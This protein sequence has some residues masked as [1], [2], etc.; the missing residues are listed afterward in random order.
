MFSFLPRRGLSPSRPV[1]NSSRPEHDTAALDSQPTGMP[2]GPSAEVTPSL[3]CPPQ[4]SRPRS[5]QTDMA[6]GVCGRVQNSV[7]MRPA[8]TLP[9]LPRDDRA[10]SLQVFATGVPPNSRVGRGPG[11][12]LF[13]V[14][15]PA[16]VSSGQSQ[17]FPSA[18]QFAQPAG[19]MP[20]AG[21]SRRPGC[22]PP[23]PD[24]FFP[25][26]PRP[27]VSPLVP[28]CGCVYSGRN[29]GTVTTLGMESHHVSGGFHS[30]S[31][32]QSRGFSYLPFTASA[33]PE[34]HSQRFLVADQNLHSRLPN[35][36]VSSYTRDNAQLPQVLLPVAADQRRPSRPVQP[37]L[38]GGHCAPPSS[39]VPP[40]QYP[41][42]SPESQ[43]VFRN[44]AR[45]ILVDVG[46]GT[47]PD[48]AA[49]HLQHHRQPQQSS[50]Q[51]CLVPRGE[52]AVA[53]DDKQ[54][55]SAPHGV[56]R[57]ETSISDDVTRIISRE[58]VRKSI[59]PSS[60]CTRIVS[61]TSQVTSYVEDN[62]AKGVAQSSNQQISAIAGDDSPHP[63]SES[64]GVL[65]SL[66]SQQYRMHVAGAAPS[67][68]THEISVLSQTAGTATPGRSHMRR[69]PTDVSQRGTEAAPLQELP[70]M[71]C[72]PAGSGSD[73][74]GGAIGEAVQESSGCFD[75]WQDEHS[76]E[77]IGEHRS[78]Y[79]VGEPDTP[80]AFPPRYDSTE[81]EEMNGEEGWDPAEGSGQDICASLGHRDSVLSE[82]YEAESGT[83]EVDAGGEEEEGTW[84]GSSNLEE[85]GAAN[86]VP[87]LLYYEKHQNPACLQQKRETHHAGAAGAYETNLQYLESEA[88]MTSE[89]LPD[90]LDSRGRDGNDGNGAGSDPTPSEVIGM[91]WAEDPCVDVQL[92]TPTY[93]RIRRDSGTNGHLTSDAK[94]L[95]S[96]RDDV[97]DS[98]ALAAGDSSGKQK[99]V[100]QRS[101]TERVETRDRGARVEAGEGVSTKAT[102]SWSKVVVNTK[103]CR[104]EKPLINTVAHRLGW[105]RQ[106]QINCKG[107]IVWLGGSVPDH[108]HLHY[109][110]P[111]Q[112]I[113]RFP[114][115][116]DM[117]KK[118]MLS[119]ILALYQQLYPDV[120]DF[121][122][123]CWSLPEDRHTIERLLNNRNQEVYILKP[124][125]GA[126][127]NGVQLVTRCR[128]I[129]AM[130]LRG[131]GNYIMQK[132]IHNPYLMNKRKF[133]FRIYCMLLSV[134]GTPKVFVSKL[135][136]ARFCTEE[137]RT[138]SRKNIDN[139]FMHLTNYSIN[140]D[141][142]SSFVRSSDLHDDNN[143]KRMLKDVFKDLA[144]DG[145]NIANVWQ[146]IKSI[147]A[148]TIVCLYPWLNLR[149]RHVY[150]GRGQ[151]ASRCFQLLGLD[152]LLDDTE[153]CWLLEVNS[154]PSLRIDYFDSKY[155]GIDV[156]LESAMDRYIKEP[157][158][159]EG[160]ALAYRLLLQ[161]RHRPCAS[162]SFLCTSPQNTSPS[163]S[164]PSERTPFPGGTLGACC[165]PP[166]HTGQLGVSAADLRKIEDGSAG[167]PT[168][169]ATFRSRQGVANRGSNVADVISRP[170]P[171]CQPRPLKATE[172]PNRRLVGRS[173]S[174]CHTGVAQR[175]GGSRE[176]GR[177]TDSRLRG[178]SSSKAATGGG[179]TKS[180][181]RKCS[182]RRRQEDDDE[183]ADEELETG[184]I[185]TAQA[186]E[187]VRQ[188]LEHNDQTAASFH[189]SVPA[190][191]SPPGVQSTKHLPPPPPGPAF[192][193]GRA[194]P[195]CSVQSGGESAPPAAY[196]ASIRRKAGTDG[197]SQVTTTTSSRAPS[198]SR[199]YSQSHDV[200]TEDEKGASSFV[201][202]T[203]EA[204]KA[205]QFTP[206]PDEADGF[207]VPERDGEHQPQ[208]V[209]APDEEPME[210]RKDSRQES[211][212]DRE[213]L[214]DTGDSPPESLPS[215]AKRTSEA[216]TDCSTYSVSE[217]LTASSSHEER[218]KAFLPVEPQ[219]PEA[220]QLATELEWMDAAYREMEKCMDCFNVLGL[221]FANGPLPLNASGTG[222]G[223]SDDDA[224]VARGTSATGRKKFHPG[225]YKPFL[226][227]DRLAA[228]KK[229]AVV[230]ASY[231]K[232][233]KD[234]LHPLP[235][236][237]A[238]PQH[239]WVDLEQAVGRLVAQTTPVLRFQL[240]FERLVNFPKAITLQRATLL[241]ACRI[242]RLSDVLRKVQVP[243]SNPVRP[244]LVPIASSRLSS[245]SS[246]SSGQ[247]ACF[248]RGLEQ[249][250]GGSGFPRTQSRCH[251][252]SPADTTGESSFAAVARRSS[253]WSSPS[254]K[255]LSFGK[256]SA[257]R[258]RLQGSVSVSANDS[259]PTA[260]GSVVPERRRRLGLA[261]VE[262]LWC[263]HLQGVRRQLQLQE[264]SPGLGL[265]EAWYVLEAV[266]LVC[267]PFFP[268]KAKLLEAFLSAKKMVKGGPLAST[269]NW[270]NLQNSQCQSEIEEALKKVEE[271]E[272]RALPWGKLFAGR[273]NTT[274]TATSGTTGAVGRCDTHAT[275]EARQHGCDQ[276]GHATEEKRSPEA[277][278]P[279][280]SHNRPGGSTRVD[281]RLTEAGAGC[282]PAPGASGDSFL[283]APPCR[284]TNARAEE[285]H[286]RCQ[287]GQQTSACAG[288]SS[289]GGS[290][291][292]AGNVLVKGSRSGRGVA[293][294]MWCQADGSWRDRRLT[295]C[296][297]GQCGT[298]SPI[299][300]AP[301]A[302]R[303]GGDATLSHADTAELHR[304]LKDQATCEGHHAELRAS[305]SKAG[306]CG[307]RLSSMPAGLERRVTGREQ[308]A[309]TGSQK[310]QEPNRGRAYDET[311]RR[312]EGA[313]EDDRG[314]IQHTGSGLTEVPVWH[315]GLCAAWP[316]I[317][318]YIQQHVPTDARTSAMERL[319]DYFELKWDYH[320]YSMLVHNGSV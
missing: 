34:A 159:C 86:G 153:K 218:R 21:E 209:Q 224:A 29:D 269:K 189:L 309:A 35:A 310:L 174:G 288:F 201:S 101:K 188:I 219:C 155:E 286:D 280:E 28:D 199:S 283:H 243:A 176:V 102:L 57:Q 319:V 223:G 305:R 136:M 145:V 252:P 41:L 177:G 18:S 265:L 308:S 213:E 277:S 95:R 315:E 11:S 140:K 215:H 250:F 79:A 278:T 114:G 103:M 85:R 5:L 91:P 240:L 227:K 166:S 87:S 12:C 37:F 298:P 151:E 246:L 9:H 198:R 107:N 306:G 249:S 92:P 200:T 111:L 105:T 59:E 45:T 221:R 207:H 148:R 263:S 264:A 67:A 147:T 69:C 82:E 254:I 316:D 117:T 169:N 178:L 26:F 63:G 180:K 260:V 168:V 190:Q 134:S 165:T 149:Y 22:L 98:V 89:V 262:A 27:H 115:M 43:Y 239:C 118:R 318:E 170:L 23:R 110:R 160:L 66:S 181:T 64:E 48:T 58:E 135:G 128:D 142:I 141:N 73:C 47:V 2:L 182:A 71:C 273:G 96:C 56:A 307:R 25:C 158:V 261:D 314:W 94:Y 83:S 203:A 146:Q 54:D 50:S 295:E 276:H 244:R 300:A 185:G 216:D 281:T 270:G 93:T 290:R 197:H 3:S 242:V 206:V 251:P 108:E 143:S 285:P 157:V 282:G 30:Q 297:E 162:N 20:T 289:E 137:Y 68:L 152:I 112:I 150:R 236:E 299:E 6:G 38:P 320:N 129:D 62:S 235:R 24:G 287:Q 317:G 70:G 36:L 60:P 274:D 126:M 154:N 256:T 241:E 127:G 259:S 39:H 10:T 13:G 76:G 222:P 90:R 220:A 238:K 228:K 156:Q 42:F 257:Y 191:G 211:L 237:H 275:G 144:R 55:Q 253:L 123:P 61:T 97:T 78:P 4:G 208:P 161:N 1:S 313:R 192:Q 116:W 266:A 121:S 138:P 245:S 130:V 40:A 99:T 15:C 139:P 7:L 88:D 258:S 296:D 267:F 84:E 171:R 106:E 14:F 74:G 226:K 196:H 167:V 113:N 302:C 77:V 194:V 304:Y 183:G 131:D 202:R 210:E 292:Q 184:E 255:S 301:D 119:R 81:E 234:I 284:Y 186:V 225:P 247:G 173:D 312:E 109:N 31:P 294:A 272:R 268:T 303:G 193:K 212:S 179:F 172:G 33:A 51:P 32:P 291:T 122:P 279:V 217:S 52:R 80:P 125:G 19:A 230:K 187:K 16:V 231:T 233:H 132:Y 49:C 53:T 100:F 293:S 232:L 271:E 104:A 204:S 8:G 205:G 229:Q 133:D 311:K 248:S 175:Q 195:S 214:A 46:P 75:S 163:Y 44:D 124:D 120:F 164:G 17:A 65:N 72:S